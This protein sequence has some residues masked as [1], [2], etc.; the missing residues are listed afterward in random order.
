MNTETWRLWPHGN[1]VHLERGGGSYI[2]FL[3][4]F[5]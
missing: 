3:L 2:F 5:F 1:V 4:H